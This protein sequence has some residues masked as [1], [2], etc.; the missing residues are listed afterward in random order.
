[1]HCGLERTQTP[2]T[3]DQTPITLS[4]TLALTSVARRQQFLIQLMLF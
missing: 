3:P 1:M 2:I 4:S